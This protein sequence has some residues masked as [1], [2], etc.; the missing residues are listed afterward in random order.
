M[1]INSLSI[2][3][4]VY[5]EKDTIR[6]ILRRVVEAPSSG[7]KEELTLV[8]DHSTDGTS[9]DAGPVIRDYE[10]G[11]RFASVLDNSVKIVGPPVVRLLPP[12]PPFG[13]EGHLGG[14]QESTSRIHCGIY[15]LCCPV[16]VRRRRKYIPLENPFLGAADDVQRLRASGSRAGPGEV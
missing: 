9:P 13:R 1:S 6:Q 16:R 15:S 8:D 4:P 5:N 2:E 7:L 12:V 3:I 10:P 14:S 11:I